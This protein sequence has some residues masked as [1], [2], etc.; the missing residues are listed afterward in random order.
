MTTPQ[1]TAEPVSPVVPATVPW[2]RRVMQSMLY[3]RN[4][5]RARKAR[6]RLGLAVLGFAI[7]IAVRLMLPIVRGD[8]PVS[9]VTALAH[10]PRFVRETPV[11][12]DY[13][14]GGFLIWNGVKPFI[15]SRADLYG[16]IFLENYADIIQP[17][18]DALAASPTG[19]VA[20]IFPLVPGID[21]AGEVVRSSAPD[22]PVGQ[23]VGLDIPYIFAPM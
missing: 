22:V 2:H 9:P 21:L 18:K 17:D 4:V 11:L 3:G 12:N 8:D 15:D 23:Q 10:V 16:D 6:A 1:D 20:R 7:L 19:R 13:A 5:D 14:F